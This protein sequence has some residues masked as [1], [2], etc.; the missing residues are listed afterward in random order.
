MNLSQLMLGFFSEL[1]KIRSA[2]K[3][4]VFNYVRNNVE[5]IANVVSCANFQKR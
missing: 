1:R 2:I 4:P 3:A 5:I